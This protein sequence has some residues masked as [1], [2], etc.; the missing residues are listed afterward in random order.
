MLTVPPLPAAPPAFFTASTS[1][2]TVATAWPTVTVSP[3]LSSSD[4]STPGWEPV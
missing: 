4:V 1:S 2:S 3:S